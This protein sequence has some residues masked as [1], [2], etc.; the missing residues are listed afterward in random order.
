MDV[1][2]LNLMR[3]LSFESFRCHITT[4]CVL[5]IVIFTRVSVCSYE[6]GFTFVQP[7]LRADNR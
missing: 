1:Y 5:Y 4:P 2:I 6:L 3:L 7:N